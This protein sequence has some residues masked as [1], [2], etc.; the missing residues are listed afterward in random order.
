MPAD[1]VNALHKEEL[2]K[3]NYTLKQ[4]ENT[5]GKPL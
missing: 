5:K 2:T 4:T 1:D 3:R